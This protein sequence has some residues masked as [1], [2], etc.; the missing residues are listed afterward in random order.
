MCRLTLRGKFTIQR[1]LRM[2]TIGSSGLRW[3]WIALMS[4][5]AVTGCGSSD[6]P[7]A[8]ALPET[9]A[10]FAQKVFTMLTNGDVGVQDSIDW[11][12]FK[13]GNHDVSAVY[14]QQQGDT[15][16]AIFRQAYIP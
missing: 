9:D 3:L 10:E 1:I 12:N 6:S 7:K 15:N 13:V 14:H 4:L 2:R 16:K 11:D 5:L 8:A